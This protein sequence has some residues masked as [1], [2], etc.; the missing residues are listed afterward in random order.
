MR[1]YHLLTHT[2]VSIGPKRVWSICPFG[3]G[4]IA[5]GPRAPTINAVKHRWR[6]PLG[7]VRAG[8]PRVPTINV[9]KHRCPTL[10][11]R[12]KS[13]RSGSAHHQR[14]KTLMVGP[15]GA[16]A[17]ARGPW[18]PTINAVK[19]RR[20]APWEVPELEMREHPPSTLANIDSDPQGGRAEESRSTHHQR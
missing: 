2:D 16:G 5:R 7:G 18:A 3:G 4:A 14:C 9:V 12:C 19:H 10:G 6:P 11:R 20:L 13:W 15:L 1:T 17:G 8:G